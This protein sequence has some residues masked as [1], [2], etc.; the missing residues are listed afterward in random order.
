[1]AGLGLAK[2]RANLLADRR[3]QNLRRLAEQRD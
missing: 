2:I 1:M 3:K